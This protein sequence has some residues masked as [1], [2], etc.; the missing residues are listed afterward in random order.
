MKLQP[1]SLKKSLNKAYLK[2]KTNRSDIENFKAN[3][4][5]LFDRIN[6][7]ESEE[8]LKNIVADFFKDTWYKDKYEIN[9]KDR[10]DLVIHTGKTAKEPVGVIL[11]VKKPSNKAE[12][13]SI[14]KPNAKAMHELILYYLG[15]ELN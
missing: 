7:Q 4:I 14:E 15:K 10:K 12:M 8:H 11:E 1:Q 3:F 9:T 13:I 2:E 6:E 5:K